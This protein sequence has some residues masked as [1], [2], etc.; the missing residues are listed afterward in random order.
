VGKAVRLQDR[1]AVHVGSE[2]DRA[3]RVADPEPPNDP[4]LAD[5]AMH[6]DA[7]GGEL[8]GDQIRGPLFLEPQLGMGVNIAA[9]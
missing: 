3:R 1:Q 5:P 6:L 7:E 2:P 8:G 9:P 4:G